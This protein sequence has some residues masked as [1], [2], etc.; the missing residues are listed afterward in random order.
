MSSPLHIS[1]YRPTLHHFGAVAG[2]CAAAPRASI[3]SRPGSRARRQSDRPD[4]D[5]AQR[6]ALGNL[7]DAHFDARRARTGGHDLGLDVGHHR[8]E[9]LRRDIRRRCA[10]ARRGSA[11]AHRRSTRSPRHGRGSPV[12]SRGGARRIAPARRRRRRLRRASVCR[13]SPTS[14]R[15]APVRTPRRWRRAACG[16]RWSRR[17]A[18]STPATS[19]NA[20][21]A[22]AGSA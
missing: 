11:T 16:W 22:A 15:R 6:A 1:Q 4:G 7:L 8:V 12:A 10:R 20:A 9:C 2:A 13:A 5:G 18:S 14:P 3:S 17:R 19:S 21:C